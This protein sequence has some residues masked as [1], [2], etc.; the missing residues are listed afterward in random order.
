MLPADDIG[1]SYLNSKCQENIWTVA[2]N[3]F[4]SEKIKVMLVVRALYCLNP[5]GSARRQSLA[6]TLR[7][8]GYVS[9]KADPG[10]WLKAET[11]T[12]GTECYAYARVYVDDVLHLH[13]DPDTFVNRLAEV[14]RLKD[15]SVGETNRY[16]GANIEKVQ[17]DDGSVAWSMKSGEYV[18]NSIQNLEDTL[19]RDGAKPL[20]IFGNKAG[21]R[22][23][24]SDY[25]P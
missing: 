18:T 6:Q 17:L 3:E 25:R 12:D 15:S 5:S 19:A 7:D 16:I 10:V 21:E 1:N 9:S 13:H 8:L 14:Y 2:G 20:M 23:F 22:L 24:P 11:K 4:G